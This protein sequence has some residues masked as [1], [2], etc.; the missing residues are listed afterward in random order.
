MR[1]AGSDSTGAVASTVTVKVPL[2]ALPT[3]SLAVQV[4]TVLPTG[5]VVPDAGAQLTVTPLGSST[6]VAVGT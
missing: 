2:D 6:S 1:L 4:T 3:G 5:K